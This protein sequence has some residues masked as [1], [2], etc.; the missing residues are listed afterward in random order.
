MV[1]QAG[2][3]GRYDDDEIDLRELFANLWAERLLI[4]LV[5]LVIGGAAA[6]YA[7][8]A[9]PYYEVKSVLQ[10]APIKD[11]DELNGSGVYT[12]T[13]EDALKRVGA[14]LA[15]YENRLAFAR[16]HEGEL[17]ALQKPGR[18]FEQ[19]FQDFNEDGFKMLQPD[20]K[21]TD[22]LTPYVGIAVT[23]PKGVDGVTLTNGFIE[24]AIDQERKKIEDDLGVVVANQLAQ[25]ERKIQAGRAAYEASKESRIATLLEADTLKRAELQDELN[26]LR[27]QLRTRRNNRITQLDE[28]I[29][30]AKAL[31]IHKPTNPT[32]LG[33][34]ERISQGNVIRTEVNSQQIPL[35]FMGSEALEA[36]RNALLKR[37]SDDFTEPRIAE[38]QKELRLLEKNRQVEVLKQREDE[39]LF[40]KDLAKWRAEAARLKALDIDFSRLNLVKVDQFASE[41]LKPAKPKKPLILAIGLVL[42][43]MLG[44]F[45]ALI[46][47]MLRKDRPAK[48]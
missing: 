31:G 36:E 17:E 33:D 16:A 1:E 34:S 8:L 46:R 44:L 15:S 21:K 26:A 28:A 45:I 43:G 37:R 18:T 20:P 32:S 25:L 7:F 27:Q 22:A 40:L 14:A 4:L 5:T 11:L 2:N 10:P 19:S 6:A 48:A 39:D 29:A 38:I 47:S 35:Y 3:P 24:F 30:I 12:L 13:P 41:P 23:Y 9:T 42:G